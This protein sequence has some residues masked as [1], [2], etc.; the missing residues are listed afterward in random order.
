[1]KAFILAGV[2]RLAMKRLLDW[3]DEASVVH[4]I[5]ESAEMPSWE[6]S[7][8]RMREEGRPSKVNFP[9]ADHLAYRIAPPAARP[10]ADLRIK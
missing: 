6:E 9:S 5:Q 3:C 4:W 1:M 7:Y 10:G 2:H 8:R